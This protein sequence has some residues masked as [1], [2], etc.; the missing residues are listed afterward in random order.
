VQFLTDTFGVQPQIMP[1]PD[2]DADIVVI[3][4]SRT[5]QIQ[6]GG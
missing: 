1:D 2:P 4:G 6:A 5:K 3:V